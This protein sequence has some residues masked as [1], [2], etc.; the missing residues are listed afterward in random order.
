MILK[1]RNILFINPKE[2]RLFNRKE[3]DDERYS[4]R[5]DFGTNSHYLLKES[6]HESEKF[7]IEVKDR[8]L[9]SIATMEAEKK[10]WIDLIDLAEKSIGKE[11]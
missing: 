4:L 2:V 8:I 7:M 3:G 6:V 11:A 5:I 9:I 1:L 10:P